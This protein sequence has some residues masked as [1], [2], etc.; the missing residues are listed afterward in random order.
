MAAAKRNSHGF[1]APAGRWGSGF[2]MCKPW[3]GCT[4]TALSSSLLWKDWM[5]FPTQGTPKC[6]A[7]VLPPLISVSHKC[8]SSQFRQ[9]SV[10]RA[11]KVCFDTSGFQNKP[12]H[13]K[14]VLCYRDNTGS[15]RW[16]PIYLQPKSRANQVTRAGTSG[17]WHAPAPPDKH[18]TSAASWNCRNISPQLQ[19]PKPA[20]A[21]WPL[22]PYFCK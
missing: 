19:E 14:I 8:E 4:L 15:P 20:T 17:T 21:G 11:L 18:L 13:L 12:K 22:K 5:R 1:P 10:P 6:Q 16:Q 7:P 2:H 3:R 9:R